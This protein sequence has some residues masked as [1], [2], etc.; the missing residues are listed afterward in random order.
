MGLSPHTFGALR[1]M[2]QFYVPASVLGL[3]FDARVSVLNAT[4]A[5]EHL[6]PSYISKQLCSLFFLISYSAEKSRLRKK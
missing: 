1:S 4:M 2:P 6:L 5:L 3:I